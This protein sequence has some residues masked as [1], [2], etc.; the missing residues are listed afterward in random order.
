MFRSNRKSKPK[1]L[2]MRALGSFFASENRLKSTFRPRGRKFWI[3][4]A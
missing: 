2:D 4:R 1:A 3:L